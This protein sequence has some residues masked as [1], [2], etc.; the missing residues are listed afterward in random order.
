MN[1][2]NE[3]RYM[4]DIL[5]VLTLFCVFAV[6]SILLIAVGARIYQNTIDSMEKHFTST[7]SLSYISEKIRQNELTVLDN[8]SLAEAKTKLV[9]ETVDN[10]GLKGSVIFVV[11][12]YDEAALRASRNIPTVSLAESRQLSVYEIVSHKN[13]VI[14]ADAIKKI[15]EEAK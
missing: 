9:A 14:T 11:S 13:V 5:F 4:V 10:L 3:N 2:N 15:E 12:E 1:S 7:T 6:C 8:F